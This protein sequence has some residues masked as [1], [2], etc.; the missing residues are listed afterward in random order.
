ME[1]PGFKHRIPLPRILT[2]GFFILIILGGLLLSLP[3]ATR[4]GHATSF[5]DALFT[6]TSAICIT[7]LTTVNTA[8]HWSV[9]GQ[10]IIMLLV[11]IGGLG[12]M[13]FTVLPFILFRRHVDL[14]TR[15]LVKES[16][17]FENL[18]DVSSVMK[19]VIGLSAL[20]QSIGAG[21]L[22]IDFYPRYGLGRGLFISVFQS[23]MAFCNAGFDLFGNSLESYQNDPYLLL[24]IS[25]LIIAGGLGFLVWRDLLLLRKRKRLSLHTKLALSTSAILLVGGTLIFSLTENNLAV[26]TPNVSPFNRLINT[27]FL[28]VT[29]RTAGLTTLPY[30][31][32]SIAGIVLTIVLMFIGG[33]SGSTAGGIKTTT[34][35]L[36]TLQSWAVLRG[37]HDVEFSKRRFSDQNI[38]R[39]LMLVFASI[40]LVVT[41]IMILTATEA[42]PAR[43]GL[44]YVTF[45]VV[46]AFSTTGM[47]LGLTPHLSVIG[48][49]IIM[50]LMFLGRVGI[51]TVMFTAL[52]TN[53]TKKGY[54]YPTENILIG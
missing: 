2:F 24:V 34:F 5:I 23:I 22:F 36:L 26:L 15:L 27:F 41:A 16:L 1:L 7:G 43:Y 47:S 54:R 52:N 8:A 53:C 18:S 13:S 11:E 19:Y 51:Y 50:L 21:L 10:S 12:F 32:L 42:T 35:G 39:A 31:Q 9:F 3:M 28:A 14:T 29:P 30:H 6:A 38:L 37:H 25:A 4:N 49:L 45:E 40:A 44:E 20:I 48:K 17:N 46:S 33:T